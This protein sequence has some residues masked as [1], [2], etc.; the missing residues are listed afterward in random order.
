MERERLD[1]LVKDPATVQRQDLQDLKAMVGRYPWFSAA[2]LL[3]A[4]GD[5]ASGDV[6]YDEQLRTTA[7][8][9]PS[10]TVLFDLVTTEPTP[11][12]AQPVPTTPAVTATAPLTIVKPEVAPIAQVRPEEPSE[13][14]VPEK[15]A[16]PPAGTSNAE[17][18]ENATSTSSAG[19]EEAPSVELVDNSSEVAI[20]PEEP[21]ATAAPEEMESTLLSAPEEADPL[22][23]LI[24]DAALSSGYAL[25]LEQ[26]P[27]P[28]PAPPLVPAPP[29]PTPPAPEPP[30]IVVEAVAPPPVDAPPARPVHTGSRRFTQWLET[31]AAPAPPPVAVPEVAPP[32][33]PVAT[34]RIADPL[35]PPVPAPPAAPAAPVAPAAPAASTPKPPSNSTKAIIDQF[36][37]RSVTPPPAKKAEF[38]TPQSAAKRSLED[39][40][41]LV[42]ET[43]AKV[44]EAQGNYSKAAAAY[45][46]LALKHPDKSA[47]FASLLQAL[48][49][50]TNK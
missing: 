24:R 49:A 4:V 10:R 47:Y 23:K 37:Q 44:Y 36:I 48:E 45:R 26:S 32:A 31:D 14:A 2:H 39:H 27:V 43:L 35:P 46:R 25:L 15:T 3:L 34:I 29:D 5:H 6:L 9:L 33:P 21:T 8:H 40:A 18:V 7:A 38:F 16:L 22:D 17:S 13:T 1:R 50:K 11:P 19:T 20:E 41:D 30:P 42:S 28:L 12:A